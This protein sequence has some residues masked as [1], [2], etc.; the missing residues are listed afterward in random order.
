MEQIV[1]VILYFYVF[2]LAGVALTLYIATV[3][4]RFFRPKK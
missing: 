4:W 1:A 3:C 2:G